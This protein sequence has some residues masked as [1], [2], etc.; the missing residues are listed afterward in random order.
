MKIRVNIL[1]IGFFAAFLS[2]C[3]EPLSTEL[4]DSSQQNSN[5]AIEVVADKPGVY[6]YVN[7]YDST[8]V[9]EPI[10]DKTTV[11]C[12]TGI[13]NTNYGI[14]ARDDYYFTQFNDKSNP[15]Y[16]ASKNLIGFVGLNMG[17]VSF[18]NVNAIVTANQVKYVNPNDKYQKM[19][20]TTIGMKYFY[21]SKID[22]PGS[23]SNFPY[24]SL[25]S[26]RLN[27]N[28]QSGQSPYIQLNISTPVEIVGKISMQGTSAQNNLSVQLSW[29]PLNAG[30]IEVIIGTFNATS[31]PMPLYRLIGSDNGKMTIPQTVLNNLVSNNS[32]E[33]LITFIRKKV[34][35]DTGDTFKDSYII[36]QS[37]HN[38][39]I[40][41][42]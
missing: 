2:S 9:V 41:L 13:R 18:N 39:K 5:V 26:F 40:Q 30:Q 31:G 20:D 42:P 3:K 10:L 15:V 37:I 14:R 17:Q 28:Q 1:I 36:A 35:E 19:K 29:N 8:G 34:K 21:A 27:Q 4:A 24:N 11:I 32:K 12:V 22:I 33:L 25:V 7:G 6:N 23:Q 38:F 16:N